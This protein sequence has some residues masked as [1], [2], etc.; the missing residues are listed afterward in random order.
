VY[1]NLLKNMDKGFKCIDFL[2]FEK[3]FIFVNYEILLTRILWHS[4]I[5]FIIVEILS[6]R[7]DSICI[8]NDSCSERLIVNYGVP[9]G[10]VLGPLLF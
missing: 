3:A 2:D 5:S 1:E 8:L 10:F 4:R 6:Q 9:Q 7:K